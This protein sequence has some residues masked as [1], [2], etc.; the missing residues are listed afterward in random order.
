MKLSNFLVGFAACAL[1]SACANDEMPD[2]NDLPAQGNGEQAFIAVRLAM[3]SAMTKANVFED[4]T[5]N[6]NKVEKARFYF[7]DS[8]GTA[9]KV[10]GESNYIE[11]NNSNQEGE[12]NLD[13]NFT[14]PSSDQNT[15]VEKKSD[16]LLVL[17]NVEKVRPAKMLVILNPQS[18]SLSS[19]TG[20]KSLTDLKAIAEAYAAKANDASPSFVMSNSVY[21]S[22][23]EVIDAVDITNYITENKEQALLKPVQ[24]YVERTVAKVTVTT[25]IGEAASATALANETEAIDTGKDFNSGS[26]EKSVMAKITGWTI[27]NRSAKTNLIKDLTGISTDPFTNWNDA[28]NFRSYWATIPTTDNGPVNDKKWSEI[29][30]FNNQYAEERTGATAG[31]EAS[32]LVTATLQLQGESSGVSIA[33][34]AGELWTID[35]L[36]T[37]FCSMI[38][39]SP[40]SKIYYK[41]TSDEKWTQLTKDQ[42]T[43]R[44]RKNSETGTYKAYQAILSLSK[45]CESGYSFAKDS[46]GTS[47]YTNI[48]DV[49]KVLNA[50]TALVY[51]QGKT[52][53]YLP[54]KHAEDTSDNDVYGLVRNHLYKINITG[55][56]GLGTPIPPSKDPSGGDPDPEEPI[57]P[58]KPAETNTFMAAEINILSWNVISQDVVLGQ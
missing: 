35:D 22:G 27:A 41:G 24:V 12:N 2:G 44:K 25:K 29:T 55:V 10:N 37:Q 9:A 45:S 32:L 34:Y 26:G 38:S 11:L 19:E 14:D 53:Y 23:N 56:T 33:Q 46:E 43:F 3:P 6:E 57:V 30:N 28:N 16:A 42:V 4:G 54:I 15:N 50:Y 8:T 31:S 47:T 1:F 7:F 36:K 40:D 58:E 21:K 17:D 48:S 20:P 49:E 5:E 13:F 51:D 52:Y 18:T 39:N